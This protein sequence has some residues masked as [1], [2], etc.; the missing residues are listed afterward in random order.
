M[1]PAPV[2]SN[3]SDWQPLALVFGNEGHGDKD[4]CRVT[5]FPHSLTGFPIL[6]IIRGHVLIQ[7]RADDLEQD[8]AGDLSVEERAS[9]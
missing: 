7:P 9:G 3:Q 4:A 2:A 6:V 5:V 8:L 1:Q